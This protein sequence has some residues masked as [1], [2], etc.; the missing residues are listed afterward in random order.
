MKKIEI[1][2]SG[3]RF[4]LPGNHVDK[5]IPTWQVIHIVHDR[6][7]SHPW[8]TREFGFTNRIP[9]KTTV[10]VPF[11]ETPHHQAS[12][13]SLIDGRL[14]IFKINQT[15]AQKMTVQTILL[16]END[17]EETSEKRD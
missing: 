10:D 1:R 11:H 6:P 14:V 2:I 3:S 4:N 7:V 12:P 17:T 9:S 16:K 13:T 8:L 15:L 5:G